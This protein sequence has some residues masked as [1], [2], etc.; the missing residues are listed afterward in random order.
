MVTF[1]RAIG[2]RPSNS[3]LADRSIQTGCPL[4]LL[5]SRSLQ[6]LPCANIIQ[7]RHLPMITRR[8]T[9]RWSAIEAGRLLQPNAS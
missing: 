2:A 3:T 8:V 9:M 6:I 1:Q 5:H 7:K 4:K